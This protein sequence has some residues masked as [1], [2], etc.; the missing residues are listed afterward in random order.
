MYAFP[1][2]KYW[3][4]L[5]SFI[6]VE[7]VREKAGKISVESRYYISSLKPDAKKL[8]EGIRGHWSIENSLH[9]CLDVVFNEDQSRIRIGHAPF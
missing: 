3:K 9:W 5:Q 4:G 6:Q 1:Y 7:S 8:S 2:K